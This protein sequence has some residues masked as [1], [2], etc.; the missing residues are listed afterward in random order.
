MTLR[1]DVHQRALAWLAI[2]FALT[3]LPAAWPTL[4]NGVAVT[5][6][7]TNIRTA[8]A[9]AGIYT[10]AFDDLANQAPGHLASD[11]TAA[12]LPMRKAHD[13]TNR[14][15][16]TFKLFKAP[17][18]FTAL[19][20]LLLSRSWALQPWAVFGLRVAAVCDFLSTYPSESCREVAL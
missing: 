20:F 3:A 9:G 10:R 12:D 6:Y 11:A 13:A 15:L 1:C 5:S 4:P 16:N 14:P 18:T 19:A 8:C 2:G 7:I 17:Y